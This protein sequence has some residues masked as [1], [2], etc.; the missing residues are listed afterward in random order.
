MATK[1]PLY[2]CHKQ[3]RA[4]R[5]AESAYSSEE[6]RLM[7][8]VMLELPNGTLYQQPVHHHWLDK[9]QPEI[10]GYFVEYGDGYISYSP[11]AAFEEGYSL[12]EG[13]DAKA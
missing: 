10:G 13:D 11:A 12:A 5:I 6:G 1:L 2:N 4:A 3:V 9:Y 8:Y 7:G